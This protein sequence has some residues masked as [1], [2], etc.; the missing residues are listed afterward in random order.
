[1]NRQLQVTSACT[2]ALLL[3]SSKIGTIFFIDAIVI[4]QLA[5]DCNLTD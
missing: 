1:M 4:T 3:Q 5:I 2:V